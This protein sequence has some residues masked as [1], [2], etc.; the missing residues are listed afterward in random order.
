LKLETNSKFKTKIARPL[1]K[2]SNI[3]NQISKIQIKNKKE[4][5]G[6]S[7]FQKMYMSLLSF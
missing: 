2:I 3:K 7:F 6:L 4:G 5:A 1:K